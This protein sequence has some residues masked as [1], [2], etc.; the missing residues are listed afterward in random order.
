MSQRSRDEEAQVMRDAKRFFGW[1]LW[2]VALALV[3][4]WAV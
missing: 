2:T 3:M 1:L 4:L